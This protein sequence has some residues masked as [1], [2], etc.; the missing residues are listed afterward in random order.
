MLRISAIFW[1]KTSKIDEKE[2]KIAE[3]QLKSVPLWRPNR[4]LIFF[5][6]IFGPAILMLSSCPN[7]KLL[8]LINHMRQ[9]DYPSIFCVLDWD[10][11]FFAVSPRKSCF[12]SDHDFKGGVFFG[13]L[14]WTF[15]TKKVWSICNRHM[16]TRV[17]AIQRSMFE[18]HFKDLPYGHTT[19]RKFSTRP[20]SSQTSNFDVKNGLIFARNFR[21]KNGIWSQNFAFSKKCPNIF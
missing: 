7:L 18:E 6:S 8:L 16:T 17:D 10:P 15:W 4:V 1:R 20:R 3:I 9:K 13:G 2:L 12:V 5:R 14:K 19:S 11:T 21:S